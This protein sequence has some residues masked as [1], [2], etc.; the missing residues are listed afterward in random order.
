MTVHSFTASDA[1]MARLLSEKFVMKSL[2]GIA[3]LIASIATPA[4]ADHPFI[5]AGE[6]LKTCEKYQDP[7]MKGE[8]FGLCFGY[9]LGLQDR[10]IVA[11]NERTF[12]M[13]PSA[14]RK[15]VMDVVLNYI[16]AN[17]RLQSKPTVGVL[18]LALRT[19]YP[20]P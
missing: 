13:S 17:P 1:I 7:K 16:R 19:T 11:G 18:S 9:I 8:L 4:I 3:F 6:F 15:I 20:C 10:D 2:I 14:N 12:C 5:T